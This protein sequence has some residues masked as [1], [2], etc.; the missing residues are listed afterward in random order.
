MLFALLPMDW[1]M[2]FG[3]ARLDVMNEVVLQ[4]PSN[5]TFGMALHVQ[6]NADSRMAPRFNAKVDGQV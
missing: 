5:E 3:H 4:R 2:I 1:L 6:G